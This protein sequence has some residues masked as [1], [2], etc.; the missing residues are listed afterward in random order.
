[1]KSRPD[2][3]CLHGFHYSDLNKPSHCYGTLQGPWNRQKLR[4]W[5][6]RLSPQAATPAQISRKSC[7]VK[8]PT[9]NQLRTLNFDND[10][11]SLQGWPNPFFTFFPNH[12][13][14]E[15]AV[16]ERPR[17][18]C[19]SCSGWGGHLHPARGTAPHPPLHCS[20]SSS[21]EHQPLPRAPGQHYTNVG[22]VTMFFK[23]NF[24]NAP[25]DILP[26]HWY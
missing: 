20:P 2:G 26:L 14:A 4:A 24:G 23:A 19:Q 7:L 10:D 16:M 3:I 25:A 1:M 18:S 8:T 17:Q 12:C 6:S 22:F 5:C 15:A 13:Q 21:R 11:E 9:F